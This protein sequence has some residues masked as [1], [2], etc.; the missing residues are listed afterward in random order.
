MDN[1]HRMMFFIYNWSM[2]TLTSYF[3]SKVSLHLACLQ[4]FGLGN[5]DQDADDI[6]AVAKYL[7]KEHD[8]LEWVLA[9][10]STGTQDAVRFMHCHGSHAI[11]TAPL[12][13]VVLLAPVRSALEDAVVV[14]VCA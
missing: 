11:G 2:A 6:L 3:F 12:K 7:H 4:Q 13:G 5:L 9:G 10:H 14:T 1:L 8:C